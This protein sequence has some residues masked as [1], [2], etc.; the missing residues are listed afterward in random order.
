VIKRHRKKVFKKSTNNE[1]EIRKKILRNKRIQSWEE[2]ERL[3]P[4]HLNYLSEK[5]GQGKTTFWL[6]L[7]EGK[8]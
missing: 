2:S 4:R 3:S 8:V 6:S 5:E 7:K 1:V